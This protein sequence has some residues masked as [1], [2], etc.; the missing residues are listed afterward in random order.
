MN[1][2]PQ[3]TMNDGNTIPQLGLGTYKMNDRQARESVR[4]ALELGYRHIDTASL[5]GNEV[6]VGQGIADAIDAGVVKRE[7]IFVTTKVWNDAQR[8]EATRA[9]VMD[10]LQKL[11][12]EYVDLVLVHWPVADNG[13]FVECYETLLELQSEGVIRSVGVANFYPEVLDKLPSAP[14]V[15]QIELHP[16]FPQEEQLADDTRRGIL[17]QAWSP[18]GRARYFE[19]SPLADIADELGKTPA[20]VT[21]RWHL[22]RGVIA[23]PKSATPERI[24]ENFEITDFELSDDHMHRIAEMASPDGR[25]SADPRNFG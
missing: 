24:R 25:Q 9:S 8:A 10:S 22:Q 2:I 7:D 12:L 15:N 16:A 18:I 17:T 21:L 23:I 3:L 14:A 5:Y 19:G 13:T 20:Q 4:Y 1:A 6:G 11:G